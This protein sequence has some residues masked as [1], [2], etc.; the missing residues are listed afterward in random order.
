[1]A[2]TRKR[3]AATER[4]INGL[5]EGDLQKRIRVLGSIVS[6]N[7]IQDQDQEQLHVVLDDGTGRIQVIITNATPLEIGNQVR[8]FG[9]LGRNEKDEYI[10]SAEIVQD[11][12]FLD[13]D[14]YQRVQAVKK[15]FKERQSSV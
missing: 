11:M 9:I 7:A 14:L 15:R 1:M 4:W 12:S 13:V 6:V 2:Q 5:T 3:R 8:I 10:L